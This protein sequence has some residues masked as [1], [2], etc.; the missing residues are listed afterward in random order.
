M[1]TF[2]S[3]ARCALACVAL[4]GACG[5]IAADAPS[6][7]AGKNY[8]RQ[9]CALCHSAEP[10]DNGG[11]QGPDL[12]GV[13]G[14]HAAGDAA[15]S[16]TSALKS[17]GL[18]WDGPTLG[19]FLAA[20]TQ[21]VPGSAMV[22]AV[23][24][25]KD[26][27]DLVAY[28]SSLKAGSFRDDSKPDVFPPP[29]WLQQPSTPV[30]GVPDWKN[31]APGRVHRLE[32]RS[33]APPYATKPARNFP[34]LV[35][36]PPGAM[37]ALPPGFSVGIFAQNLA[38]PRRMLAAPNGDILLTETQSGRINVLRPTADGTKA[39]TVG[40]YAQGLI[41]PFG[42]AFYPVSGEPEW[43]YVAETN[44]IVRYAYRS[45]DLVARGVPEVVV[46]RLAP[47]GGGHY[48][49]DLAFSP[50]GRRLFV[51]VGSQSNIAENMPGMSLAKA[52]AWDKTHA[53]GAAWGAEANRANVLVFDVGASTPG[54]I[55]A[56]GLRNCVGLTV[57]PATGELWCTVNER[58]MLGDDLVPDYSTRVRAGGFYGW[59]WYYLGA[60]EDPRLAGQRPDLRDKVTTPDVLYQAHSAALTLTFYTATS[61]SAAFPAEYVGDGF[62][63][64]HGSWNR[65]F[66]TGHKIVRVRMRNGVPTG[67]YEDFLT[68]FIAD[69]DH[70]W[71]RPVA[72]VVARDGA[73]L[74]SEDGNG[75]IYRIAWQRPAPAGPPVSRTTVAIHSGDE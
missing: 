2:A 43:L 67:E 75:V 27:A 69:N 9:Q 42:M 38:G 71:A 35:E 60:H 63:V 23:P 12:A 26:R 4:F 64:F 58:D 29:E 57:Q 47:M 10:G 55:Y 17:S 39:E 28:F 14:R 68:G 36:R 5:S 48:T 53:V 20:P 22:I 34:R 66:R 1:D 51:S 15:F 33:L 50:D 41:Q 40:V 7:L 52:R 61:G 30:T 13:F 49:R 19:R 6:A 73:L 72:T 8:F 11:A 59:P 25:A 54:R 18:S 44:R 16:Y 65:G 3:V 62:A 70:A 24:E 37:L 74:L 56:T 21:V 31:D 32:A 46:P 45:G